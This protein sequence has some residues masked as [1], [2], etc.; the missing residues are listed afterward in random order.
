MFLQIKIRHLKLY[1]KMKNLK[2]TDEKCVWDSESRIECITHTLK[3]NFY[4]Q[5]LLNWIENEIFCYSEYAEFSLTK[6]YL[7]V[8]KCVSLIWKRLFWT[9]FTI[10]VRKYVQMTAKHCSTLLF[11]SPYKI[12]FIINCTFLLFKVFH[13]STFLK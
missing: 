3:F 10:I 1:L 4:I 5:D 11:M 12:C 6:R 2:H 13:K 8:I 7:M 9:I